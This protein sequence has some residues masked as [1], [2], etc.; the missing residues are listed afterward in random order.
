MSRPAAPDPARLEASLRK[1]V[2]ALAATPRVPGTAAHAQAAVYIGRHLEE[3]GLSVRRQ[4]CATPE[5]S[6]VNLLAESVAND[7]NLPLMIFGAHY[8]SIPRTNGADDNA[9]GVAALLEIARWFAAGPLDGPPTARLLL[10]AYD[11]EE[12][13]YG[14]SSAHAGELRRQSAT[15]R[16]MVSLEMLGFTD[17]RPGSQHLP[18]QLVQL[19]PSIGN[20]IGVCGNVASQDL[21]ATVVSAMKAIPG[22]PVESIAVPDNGAMLPEV[23]LSDH[24]SFWDAGYPALMVTDT[25]FFRNPHYHQASDTP[26][27]LNYEFLA[28]VSAGACLAAAALLGAP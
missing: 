2:A 15:L 4:S 21:I 16:G 9:T 6:G 28:R 3:A 20:F 1:H 11:L 10:A 24:S 14:G 13:G 23:R 22:L 18:P 19:Y 8:D 7:P 25:S 27:T 17:L 12:Y 5:W 26:N